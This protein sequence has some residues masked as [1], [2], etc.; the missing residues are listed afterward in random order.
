MINYFKMKNLSFI[1]L[2]LHF[3]SFFFSFKESIITLYDN[4]LTAC[5]QIRQIH[6]FLLPKL[7]FPIHLYLSSVGLLENQVCNVRESLRK[8]YKK[9]VI[10]LK[11]YAKEFSRYQLFFNLNVA[12]Y[13]E[14][15][16]SLQSFLNFFKLKII[17]NDLFL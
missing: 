16:Y 8:A 1:N 3:F 12:Q 5:H 14:W 2:L 10:P 11:A 17:K 7:K 9:S 6:P 4:A 15:V 13:I